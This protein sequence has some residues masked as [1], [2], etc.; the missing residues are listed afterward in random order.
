ML[1]GFLAARFISST[2]QVQAGSGVQAQASGVY[3]LRVQGAQTQGVDDFY[4]RNRSNDFGNILCIWILEPLGFTDTNH[5][6]IGP[7]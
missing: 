7:L 5:E 2:A 3:T 4:T 6:E 1:S